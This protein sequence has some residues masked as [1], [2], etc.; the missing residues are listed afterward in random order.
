MPTLTKLVKFSWETIKPDEMTAA[1]D[2]IIATMVSEGKTDGVW[3][4][5]LDADFGG[6]MGFIDQSSA[7]EYQTSIGAL[8][9][10]Y[11]RIL[12]SSSITDITV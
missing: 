7:E 9:P 8:G 3:A 12:I 10:I 6:Q 5:N 4:K 11:N 2:A 1:A